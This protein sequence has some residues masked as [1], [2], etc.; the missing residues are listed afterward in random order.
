[1]CVEQ[2][3][4]KVDVNLSEH[5]KIYQRIEDQKIR[6]YLTSNKRWG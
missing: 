4:M 2:Y 1:M 6:R 3:R 5:I